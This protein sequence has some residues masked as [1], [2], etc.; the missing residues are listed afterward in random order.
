MKKVLFIFLFLTLLASSATNAQTWK[1]VR[2]ELMYGTGTSNCF[3]DLGGANLIGVK[4]LSI[5][6][7]QGAKTLFQAKLD[8][9]LMEQVKAINPNLL[10]EPQK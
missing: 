6:Q 4:N 1:R 3:T 8:P 7:L 2:Y 10:K 9:E 5:E